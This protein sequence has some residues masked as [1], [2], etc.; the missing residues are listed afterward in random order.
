MVV[1]VSHGLVRLTINQYYDIENNQTSAALNSSMDFQCTT[2]TNPGV[3]Q[4]VTPVNNARVMT[5]TTA[6]S[7]A[8][9]DVI[10]YA[11][12]QSEKKL[13]VGPANVYA[14]FVTNQNN[15]VRLFSG[16]SQNN[17][18]QFTELGLGS[19]LSSI[20]FF[21]GGYAITDTASFKV[22]DTVSVFIAPKDLGV[23]WNNN[24]YSPLPSTIPIGMYEAVDVYNSYATSLIGNHTHY[25]ALL[26]TLAYPNTQLSYLE[27]SLNCNANIEDN[28]AAATTGINSIGVNPMCKYYYDTDEMAM[29]YMINETTTD[30]GDPLS[31]RPDFTINLAYYNMSTFNVIT[32][33][34]HFPTNPVA[35]QS[36]LVTFSSTQQSDTTVVWRSRPFGSDTYGVWS[37]NYT[38]ESVFLHQM[39]IP[40][41][42]ILDARVYQYYVI[43]GSTNETNG[44]GYY[45]F[46]VGTVSIE[47]GT[48]VGDSITNLGNSGFC[49]G[50]DCVYLFMGLPI[51]IGA[52]L[53][54]W[55]KAGRVL[56]LAVFL[57]TVTALATL[58]LLPIII[59][60]PILVLV[61]V[62]V[63]RMFSHHGGGNG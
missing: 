60:L 13:K 24:T 56:G 49:S 12:S 36:V 57:V 18:C 48:P 50:S 59:L 29:G 55:W 17:E 21:S 33:V 14:Y 52:T 47:G 4:G 2:T 39:Y 41:E 27:T 26:G 6:G 45:S 3:Q 11:W 25:P 42:A 61:A 10:G 20:P 30:F 46:T 1:P 31:V 54:S 63:A 22:N 51:L 32:Y 43:A 7:T 28:S 44:T 37:S 38:N 34:S 8:L 19:N 5:N 40:A 15:Y 53:F 16:N 58:Q 23:W 35:N 62:I 9:P